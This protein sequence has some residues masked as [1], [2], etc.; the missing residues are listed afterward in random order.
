[1]PEELWGKERRRELWAEVFRDIGILG[2]VFAPLDVILAGKD[3][4][5]AWLSAIVTAAAVMVVFGV[6]LDPRSRPK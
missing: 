5:G 4:R 6:R 2:L 1:V 3:W